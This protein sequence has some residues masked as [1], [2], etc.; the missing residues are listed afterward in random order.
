MLWIADDELSVAA[1]F[2]EDTSEL[3]SML[4]DSIELLLDSWADRVETV[5]RVDET[6]SPKEVF[7]GASVTWLLVDDKRFEALNVGELAGFE[8]PLLLEVSIVF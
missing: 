4:C 7:V 5:V 2:P 6:C 1:F 8:P 3:V